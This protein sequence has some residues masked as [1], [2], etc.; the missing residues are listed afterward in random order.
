MSDPRTILVLRFS[1]IGDIVHTTSVIGTLK[2]YLPKSKIDF[3]TLSKF[4]P[5]LEGHPFINKIHAVDIDGGY[6]QLRQTGFEMEMMDYDL[7]HR[8]SEYNS[9]SNYTSWI[10]F[11]K[12]CTYQKTTLEP[13]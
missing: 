4:A 7:G 1:S 12:T 5:L 6:R 8:P 2:K 9:I 13:V 10:Y 11:N 3:M